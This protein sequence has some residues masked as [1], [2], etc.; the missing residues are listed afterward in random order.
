MEQGVRSRERGAWG[1]EQRVRNWERWNEDVTMED[2]GAAGGRNQI[3]SSEF[4]SLET[5]SPITKSLLCV[6]LQQKRSRGSSTHAILGSIQAF[7]VIYPQD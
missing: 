6:N 1:A 2:P 7:I 4:R 3:M 5:S